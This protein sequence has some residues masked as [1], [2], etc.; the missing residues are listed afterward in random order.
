MKNKK[1]RGVNP[2]YEN[3]WGDSSHHQQ[4]HGSSIKKSD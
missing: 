1:V 2:D 4:Q 3:L